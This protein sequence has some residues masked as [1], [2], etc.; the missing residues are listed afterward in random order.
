MKDAVVVINLTSGDDVL[1]IL[2]SQTRTKIKVEH[3]SFVT[4]KS[5]ST[6]I[7]LQPFCPL[8]DE[9]FFEIK[10]SDVRYVAAA[11]D[12]VAAKFIEAIEEM[13]TRRI[14]EM[15]EEDERR[16]QLDNLPKLKPS[17][18]LSEEDILP[19]YVEGNK[20]KH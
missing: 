15:I 10:M 14:L 11:A 1:A 8:S 16:R 2:H 18:S 4:Y 7:A 20:T 12:H 6:S 3:P 5:S 17:T 19:Q 9:I 13:E